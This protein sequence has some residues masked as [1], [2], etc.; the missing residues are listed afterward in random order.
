MLL[1]LGHGIGA[2]VVL[3]GA[4]RR[5]ASGGAGEVGFLPMPGAGGLPSATD[6]DGGLH[7]LAGSAAICALARAHGLPADEAADAP[8]A[9]AV[10]RLATADDTGPRAAFLDELAERVAVAIAGVVAVLDPG[11]AVLGGEV[12]RAGGAALVG[13]VTRRLRALSPLETEVRAATVTG[14]PV[15]SGAL[16]TALDATRG[17][18]FGPGGLS[19]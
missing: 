10:V 6:C 16:L 14:S 4:L 5:G 3:D 11:T 17:E 15:L 8:A 7:G 19:E 12:G 13:R 1:W 18:L 2:A 9:E